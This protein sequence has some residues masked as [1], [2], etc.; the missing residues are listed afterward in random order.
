MKIKTRKLNLTEREINILVLI[1]YGYTNSEIAQELNL[2]LANTYSSV[3][4][5]LRKTQ[6]I[7]RSALVR[8]GFQNKYL[9]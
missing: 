5:L 6:A 8:W 9:K 3:C 1:S 4:N 7:N 2:G